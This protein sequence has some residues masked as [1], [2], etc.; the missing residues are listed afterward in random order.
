[1]SS[2]YFEFPEFIAG[3]FQYKLATRFK[4]DKSHIVRSS[5]LP[6]LKEYSLE[7]QMHVDNIMRHLRRNYKP[8]VDGDRFV[9]EGTCLQT[10]SP[11][12]VTFFRSEPHKIITDLLYLSSFIE[13]EPEFEIYIDTI[14]LES[15]NRLL[16]GVWLKDKG[17]LVDPQVKNIPT[18]EEVIFMRKALARRKWFRIYMY[19]GLI[20]Y[21]EFRYM[22]KNANL[23]D[24]EFLKYPH[25]DPKSKSLPDVIE[26]L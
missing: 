7:L 23:Y 11:S 1:M 13:F 19:R 9:F 25:L 5:D 12:R 26:I 14:R 3:L 10:A 6:K 20:T 8:H 17:I 4:Y 15:A 2:T 22:L 18:Y 21:R 16:Y 24:E